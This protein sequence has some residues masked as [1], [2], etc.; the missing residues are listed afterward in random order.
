MF[1]FRRKRKQKTSAVSR[2]TL[3]EGNLRAA[4]HLRVDGKVDGGIRGL[5]TANGDIYVSE[6][7][8]IEGAEIRGHDITVHGVVKAHVYAKGKL[9]LGATAR[10]DGD[11][12]AGIINVHPGAYYTGYLATYDS[13][14]PFYSE[15]QPETIKER[16][17]KNPLTITESAKTMPI[18][19]QV[20]S[21]VEAQIESKRAAVAA[22]KTDALRT[23]RLM[24]QR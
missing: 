24:Q 22:F 18:E 1:W 17:E 14:T 2:E 3:L 12:I 8:L 6:T 15:R 9:T 23:K 11:A 21:Q 20:K 5:I 7:G 10:M 13:R 16:I 19:A 4:G